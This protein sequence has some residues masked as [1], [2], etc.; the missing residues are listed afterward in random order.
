MKQ[1]M[2][3]KTPFWQ[4]ASDGLPIFFGYLPI[5]FAYGMMTVEGGLPAWSALLISATNMTSAGQVAG[6]QLLISGAFYLEI[7]IT[8]LVINLRYFLMSLSLSQRLDPDMPV[9]QRCLLSFGNT[10]EIFAV[11]MQQPGSL[12][13]SYLSGLIVTPYIGWTLGTIL[14]AT[15]T[16]LMP[17]ALRSALGIALYGMFL[18][19]IIPPA[20]NMKPVALTVAVA[21]A[22]GCLCYFA[23]GLRNISSGWVIIIC[24]LIAAGLAASLFPVAEEEE[25]D[26]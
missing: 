13:A 7:M 22:L 9:W 26:A 6:T 17:L 16:G 18:A 10:D 15:M 12:K 2:R 8:T 25:A 11:A 21:G 4:G 24:A 5:A 19:I 20:R 3:P 23:P 14:G 1:K